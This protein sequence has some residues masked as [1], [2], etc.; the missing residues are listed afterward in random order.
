MRC[1]PCTC[2]WYINLRL[3]RHPILARASTNGFQQCKPSCYSQQESQGAKSQPCSK[4]SSNWPFLENFLAFCRLQQASRYGV[5]L[6]EERRRWTILTL[7]CFRFATL[8]IVAI[9]CYVGLD[10]SICY[11]AIILLCKQLYIDWSCHLIFGP[12][13]NMGSLLRAFLF[14]FLFSIFYFHWTHATT[15]VRHAKVFCAQ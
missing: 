7:D 11:L 8:K 10:M 12:S 5:R 2:E 9:R 6:A 4:R 1:H 3:M 14:F 15:Q 13:L